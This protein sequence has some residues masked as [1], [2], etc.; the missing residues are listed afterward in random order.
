MIASQRLISFQS[1]FAVLILVMIE[2][3]A[4]AP[5][6]SPKSAQSLGPDKEEIDIGIL[7]LPYVQYTSGITENLD[8]GGAI[9]IQLGYDASIFAKY[10]IINEPLGSSV[11]IAGGIGVGYFLIPTRFA[12]IGP[13]WSHHWKS[14]EIVVHPRWNTVQWDETTLEEEQQ[15]VTDPNSTNDEEDLILELD[16]GQLTYGQFHLGMY[17]WFTERFA[18]SVSGIGFFGDEGT[19]SSGLLPESSLLFQF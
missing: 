2:S 7:S 3:C 13:V 17:F 14:F 10:S 8:L 16:G 19:F 11:A 18:L 12:Y 1:L 15:D 5:F 4:L 9:G 6:S